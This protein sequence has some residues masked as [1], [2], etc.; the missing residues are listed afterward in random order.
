M[1]ANLKN[2]FAPQAVAQ[3]LKSLPVLEST[4]MDQYFKQRPTHP[5][6]M[7]GISDLRA[8]VQTVPVVRRDGVPVPLDNESMETQFFAPL[9]IKVQV[10]VSAAELNDLRVLLGNAASLEAWRTRKVEQIRQA[11]HATTEGMCSGVLTTGKLAWPVQLP[12]G[13][14]EAYGIDYGAP[15]VHEPGSKLTGTSKLSDVYRLLRSMQEKIRK[16]GIGGKVE[17]LCGE[18]VTAVFLDMAENWKSTAQNAPLSI[19]L[20][21]GEVQIGNFAIRFM[22]ET[23]PAPV[24]GEWVPKLD[25]KTLMAVAVDVPG[26]IWYCAIDSISANNSAVPLHIVPVKSDDDS[27]ITLIGQ[28]KPMPARPSRAVCKAVVVD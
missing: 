19:K 4:I 5:L 9:P 13:R 1:L 27:G 20:G 10:P 18:D 8:V 2:I 15:L 25:A 24:T 17:F 14:S 21:N 23:Y 6:S 12:G 28:S 26:T 7:L 3:S 11:I 22:D 16:E